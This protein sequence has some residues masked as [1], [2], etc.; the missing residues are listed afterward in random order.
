[1]ERLARLRKRKGFSQRALAQESGVSPATIYAL[2][3]ARREP[4]PSTLRKLAAAL[5]VEVADL[6]EE[7]EA[8]KVLRPRSLDELLARN[9]IKTRWL[10]LP[11]EEFDSWWLGVEWEEAKRRFW[12][13]DAEYRAIAA[14]TMAG[15][16]GSS[17]VAPE[18]AQDLAETAQKRFGQHLGAMA[19]A[20]GKDETK[21]EFYERQ[22]LQQLRQFKRVEFEQAAEEVAAHAG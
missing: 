19:A 4:N 12:Q 8:P 14:E 5:G 11:N 9:G 3:K 7:V 13:I 6:L 1:M 20:P 15:F 18:L 17:T 21:Q 16:R 2:E 22:R 10:I